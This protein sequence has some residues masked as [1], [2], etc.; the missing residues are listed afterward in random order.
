[1]EDYRR[2]RDSTRKTSVVTG[3]AATVLC[4]LGLLGLG[5]VQGL[6]YTYPPPEE[7]GIEISFEQETAPEP[8]QVEAGV[9]PRSPKADPDKDIRLAKASQAPYQGEKANETEEAVNDDFGDVETPEP[10]D[11]EKRKE[12][13]KRALFPSA[14]NKARKD[15]LAA[16]TAMKVSNALS[17]GHSAGNTVSGNNE[18]A[19]SAKLKGRTLKGSLP[20]PA[21]EEEA[22]GKVVV[23][24]KVDQYGKVTEARAGEGSTVTSRVLWKA[25]EEAAMKARFNTSSSAPVIQE[26]T[27]TYIFRIGAARQK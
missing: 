25:A 17:A 23:H 11:M 2:Q 13:D 10:R 20:L 4:H 19:P 12:I 15:S 26:G 21:Y 7:E 22:S 18:D 16:Q 14:D 9:Q 3:L 1:M 24:I 5:A 27:I 8:I 6:K